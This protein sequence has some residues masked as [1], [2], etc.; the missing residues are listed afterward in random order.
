MTA[1]IKLDPSNQ[2]MAESLEDSRRAKSGGGGPNLFGGDFTAKL[3]MN[4][5]TRPFLSQPDFLAMLRDISSDPQSM[6]KYL[7]D[8]RFQ[9]RP[10]R[11]AC[12]EHVAPAGASGSQIEAH[13]R[14]CGAWITQ[15]CSSQ[16]VMRVWVGLQRALNMFMN[17]PL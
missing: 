4:P 13:L 5:Q 6:S 2:Q 15:Q 11:A 10:R 12:S 3:A 9:V 16:R 17:E 8:P 7:N 1:G 14:S